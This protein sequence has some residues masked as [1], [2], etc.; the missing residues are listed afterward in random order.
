[1][2]TQFIS[3]M[4][5]CIASSALLGSAPAQAHISLFGEL[6]TFQ[7][8]TGATSATGPLPSLPNGGH[9]FS[10]HIGSVTFEDVGGYGFYVG[11]LEAYNPPDWTSQLEGNEIAV[12]H[13]EN[14]NVLFDAPVFSAGFKFAEPGPDSLTS[15][16]ANSAYYPFADSQFT[17]T[18]MLGT[19]VVGQFNY[20]APEESASFVGV[21]SDSAFDRM[22][23]R[24]TSDG[25]ED[26]YFGEF[27]SGT[28][29]MPVPE[30]ETHALL[31][32]G[33]A[34]LG[35]VAHRRPRG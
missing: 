17:V 12:N 4:L 26:D 30:P 13:V 31:L 5:F 10:E 24:E 18:L 35:W 16:Y 19:A 25:I 27:Y 33:L 8:A 14:L 29:A 22:E 32:A 28:T 2:E 23:I 3:R 9:H 21:W 6:T 1:M 20:N 15:P 11:G 34:V 7:A